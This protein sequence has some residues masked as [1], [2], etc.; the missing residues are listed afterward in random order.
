MEAIINFLLSND[1]IAFFCVFAFVFFPWIALWLT[2]V[3]GRQLLKRI[4][5]IVSHITSL[6]LI[7]IG[8]WSVDGWLERIFDISES[9]AN[10]EGRRGLL[11]FILV[12]LWPII[13]IGWGIM[14]FMLSRLIKP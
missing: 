6:Y 12:T 4:G 13:T 1:T 8:V 9:L 5:I 11:G 10:Y 3:E 7:V 2:E 14:L